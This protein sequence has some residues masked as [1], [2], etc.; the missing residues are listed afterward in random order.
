MLAA[1]TSVAFQTCARRM[2]AS[3][4]AGLTEC[5]DPRESAF[6]SMHAAS[7][8]TAIRAMASENLRIIT[9]SSRK[10][11]SNLICIYSAHPRLGRPMRTR[12][13]CKSRSVARTH[14]HLG[15]LGWALGCPVQ[16]VSRSVV[17]LHR[18]QTLHCVGLLAAVVG[19]A[20]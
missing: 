5:S 7:A 11:A 17:R 20:T 8:M 15:Q 6:V 4:A 13:T 18:S 14:W 1:R 2:A 16:Y 19:R 3:L 10:N 12:D 9:L